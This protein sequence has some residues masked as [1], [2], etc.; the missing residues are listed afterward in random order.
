[1]EPVI[2]T[3][4]HSI[5]QR[6]GP[7]LAL[8]LGVLGITVQDATVLTLAALVLGATVPLEWVLRAY[9]LSLPF[10]AVV[11]V[12]TAGLSRYLA[13]AA[14][15][16]GLRHFV[17]APPGKNHRWLRRFNYIDW[18]VV[19]F[20]ALILA[21]PLFHNLNYNTYSPLVKTVIAQLLVYILFKMLFGDG[22]H[23]RDISRFLSLS[24]GVLA[25]TVVLQMA[26]WDPAYIS[27]DDQWFDRDIVM[28]LARATGTYGDPNYAALVLAG[29]LPLTIMLASVERKYLWSAVAGLQVVATIAT[30]SRMGFLLLV[31]IGLLFTPA[32]VR[33]V[34]QERIRIIVAVTL[35]GILAVTVLP[36]LT[37]YFRQISTLRHLL[38]F[39]LTQDPSLRNRWLTIVA[40]LKMVQSAPLVGVGPSNYQWLVGSLVDYGVST[41]VRSAAHNAYLEVT[42]ELGLFGLVFYLVALGGSALGFIRLSRVS[43]GSGSEARIARG[44]AFATLI[45]AL[46]GL[47][48]SSQYDKYLWILL[49]LGSAAVGLVKDAAQS[50]DDY[51][52]HV[53][54]LLDSQVMG[55][56]ERHIVNLLQAATTQGLSCE[57]LLLRPGPVLDLA[58]AN[59]VAVS[60]LDIGR[61]VSLPGILTLLRY[62]RTRR[63]DLIHTHGTKANIVGIIVGFFVDVPVVTT[64]HGSVGAGMRLSPIKRGLLATVDT[65]VTWFGNERIFTVSSALSTEWARRVGHPE[66]VGPR[67]DG[68]IRSAVIRQ[69]S[70]KPP[71]VQWPSHW[72]GSPPSPL[73][74]TVGRLSH[75]KGLDILLRALPRVMEHYPTIG[76]AAIGDGEERANLETLARDLG[77][78]QAVWFVG[79]VNE[80][81]PLMA[82]AHLLI[83]PSRSEGT[84]LA[85]LEAMALGVPVVGTRVGG[86]PELLQDGAAGYLVDAED[87]HQLAS[88]IV[89]AL[90]DD[91]ERR[92]KASIARGA[93]KQY[94]ASTVAK[95]VMDAYQTIII[96]RYA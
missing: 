36:V 6:L 31:L 73:I 72:E 34:R 49:A 3:H 29:L 5:L 95:R 33:W 69:N 9:L 82:R 28:G 32:V 84:P 22:R 39:D 83:Q 78:E 8:G 13:I 70:L 93:L 96:G 87:P 94:E 27:V 21:A 45:T 76:W 55:G 47:L 58:K 10:R 43:N 65:L 50:G 64:K 11:I 61:G 74:V 46:G 35:L 12:P 7:I 30:V 89:A 18:S 40:G 19:G 53:I 60:V 41:S 4:S 23:L 15:L 37:P 81:E 54:H 44:L 42:A 75:E 51:A 86:V 59:G 71:Q 56:A 88:T 67:L 91:K 24:A 2:G 63:V 48:I 26:G 52:P 92:E 79:A 62:V 66:S 90:S 25:L 20:S 16:A 68:A 57:L 1:M 77:L 80:I 85:V 14:L 38:T 17:L